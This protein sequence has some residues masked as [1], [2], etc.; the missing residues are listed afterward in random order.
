MGGD[1]PIRALDLAGPEDAA[2]LLALQLAAYEVEA[3]L[4]GRR[5]L[6][7]LHDTVDTLRACGE[8]FCGYFESGELAGAVSYGRLGDTVDLHRVMVRPASFRRGIARAL[9]AF[10]EAR[11]ADARR[12]IVSTG[13][14]NTPARR[15]YTRLGFSEVGEREVAPG[16]L[17]TLF[18][19]TRV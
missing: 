17:I 7:P 15:L 18:E 2:L 1:A 3:A 19:K 8:T 16:L 14:L 12:L 6:P 5:D 13:S 10:V 11:E 9:V 4:I